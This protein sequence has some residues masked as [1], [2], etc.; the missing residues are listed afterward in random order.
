MSRIVTKLT[1][2]H[3]L[4]AKTQISLG[5]CPVF[6]VRMRTFAVRIE[7]KAWSLLSDLTHCPVLIWAK[8]S[9]QTRWMPRLIWVFTGHTCHFVG[10]DM[11]GL[12][13]CILMIVCT[14]CMKKFWVLGYPK[15][16]AKV[17]LGAHAIFQGSVVSWLNFNCWQLT[18]GITLCTKCNNRLTDLILHVCNITRGPLVLYPSPE[19]C[20]SMLKSAVIEEKKFK[21]SPWAWGRQPI[22]AKILMSTGRPHHYGHLLQV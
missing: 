14:A 7:C 1:K 15:N 13:L 6:A 21:H 18:R 12:K 16:C 11:R 8:D 19:C 4:P 3:V 17:L 5:I 9:Y 2:W 22:R 10:S 20:G